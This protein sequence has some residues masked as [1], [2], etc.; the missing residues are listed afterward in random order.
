MRQRPLTTP[1]T[2]YR[3][4][5]ASGMAASSTSRSLYHASLDLD[6]AVTT[7][8]NSTHLPKIGPLRDDAAHLRRQ[9]TDLRDRVSELKHA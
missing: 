1:K 5:S 9:V 3:T 2:R 8:D 4:T 6:D 7:L